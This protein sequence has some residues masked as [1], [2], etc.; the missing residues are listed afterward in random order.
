MLGYGFGSALVA[1]PTVLFAPEVIC[2]AALGDGFPPG[3]L[4]TPTGVLEVGALG[5]E[6]AGTEC[7]RTAGL[8]A[9]VE[10]AGAPEESL[11]P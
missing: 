1:A 9:T 2:F 8:R 5:L 3:Y 6:D 7:E 11:L 10:G 4:F